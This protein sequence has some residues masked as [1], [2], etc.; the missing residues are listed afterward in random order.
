MVHFMKK[1]NLETRSN[2]LFDEFFKITFAT[3]YHGIL[4]ALSV[5]FVLVCLFAVLFFD[6]ENG[7]NG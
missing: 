5:L 2:T 4:N 1:N 6:K 3:F 7:M